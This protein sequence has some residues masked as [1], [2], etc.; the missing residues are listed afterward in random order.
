MIQPVRPEE[1]P[2]A[3]VRLLAMDA[4]HLGVSDLPTAEQIPETS[5][6]TVLS[7]GSAT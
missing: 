5:H 6:D 1:G 4:L 7:D 2:S 3:G